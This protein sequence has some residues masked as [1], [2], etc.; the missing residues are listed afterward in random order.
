M[1]A[2][3]E[4]F[5]RSVQKG[6]LEHIGGSKE[7][8]KAMKGRGEF[9]VLTKIPSKVKETDEKDLST[10]RNAESR[11]RNLEVGMRKVEEKLESY[12]CFRPF[13]LSCL[14]C[15]FGLRRKNAPER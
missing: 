4:L 14:I 15:P 2:F 7:F 6:W 3:W 13:V 10:I 1:D 12:S 8:L 9:K 11:K 5:S